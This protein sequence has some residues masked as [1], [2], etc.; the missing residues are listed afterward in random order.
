MPGA[1]LRRRWARAFRRAPFYAQFV[2]S[3]AALFGA[4]LGVNW[5]Y[6]VAK[7]PSELFFPVS[8]TLNKSPE[9]TWASYQTLF[10]AHSTAIITPEFLAALAQIEASGNPVARTYWRWTVTLHPFEVYRPASSAVGMYQLT[11]GTFDQARDLCIHDHRVVEDGPWYAWRSCWFNALYS[12]VL[13][14]DAIELTSAYLD[15]HVERLLVRHDIAAATLA[16]KQNAAALMH[17]CGVG[18]ADDY[19]ARR[20]RLRAGQRCGDH[21]AVGYVTH[22]NEM[23]TTFARLAAG[24][25]G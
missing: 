13:P 2:L 20:F 9:E 23:K 25:G 10:R 24:Q 11:D 17:L 4:W 1:P 14:S 19:V 12:R 21:S 6:Q 22:V 5:T 18:V 3:V 15:Y 8:G 16:Q 7:K